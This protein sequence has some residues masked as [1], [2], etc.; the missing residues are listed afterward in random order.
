MSNKVDIRENDIV[1]YD[2]QLLKILLID[3]SKPLGKEKYGNIIWATDINASMGDGYEEQDEI[4]IE[5][6][7]DEHG[8]LKPKKSR[9]IGLRIKQRFSPHHGYVIDRII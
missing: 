5:T 4:T 6:I 2:I 1:Q 3:R 7:S 8:V 9:N